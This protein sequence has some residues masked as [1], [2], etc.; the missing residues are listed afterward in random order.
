M[1]SPLVPHHESFD[2]EN[3]PSNDILQPMTE[4]NSHILTN[5]TEA[6][7]HSSHDNHQHPVNIHLIKTCAASDGTEVESETLN[8]NLN[9]QQYDTS[10]DTSMEGEMASSS[11]H[12]N[13]TTSA[14]IEIHHANNEKINLFETELNFHSEAENGTN[15][16]A[17]S[18]NQVAAEPK[19]NI[20]SDKKEEEEEEE[21]EE[22]I[23]TKP[24]PL[25]SKISHTKSEGHLDA[26][27]LARRSPNRSTVTEPQTPTLLKQRIMQKYKQH[28]QQQS[29]F[30]TDTDTD[31]DLVLTSMSQN[32]Y[33][34]LFSLMIAKFFRIQSRVIAPSGGLP[35]NIE[36]IRK[37]EKANRIIL[38]DMLTMF[39][40][41]FSVFGIFAIVWYNIYF[42]TDFL[43]TIL[44]GRDSLVERFYFCIKC[45]FVSALIFPLI[46]VAIVRNR[47]FE[48][49]SNPLLTNLINKEH[50]LKLVIL[51]R[52]FQNS[53]EQFLMHSMSCAML[54]YYLPREDLRILVFATVTFLFCRLLFWIG[55][56]IHHSLRALGIVTGAFFNILLLVLS[57]YYISTQ[58][59]LP[60]IINDMLLPIF[61]IFSA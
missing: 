28:I 11:S 37:Q 46:F 34:R 61:V 56:S 41:G 5:K 49:A 20:E 36:T 4:E 3:K 57:C 17:V 38:R 6:N 40:S 35:Q 44:E 33:F 13:T 47:L 12:F 18:T 54:S 50:Q 48:E 42:N 29:S 58:D 15:S 60:F 59:I 53:I 55:Y 19:N 27:L 24:I 25:N 14:S 23:S 51:Q 2:E 8:N 32:K 9:I 26:F 30:T 45:I 16:I 1:S 31:D 43:K 22:E 21:E 52:I 39:I 7:H 10:V